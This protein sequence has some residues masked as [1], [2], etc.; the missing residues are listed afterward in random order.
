MLVTFLYSI[1]TVNRWTTIID[2]YGNSGYL[3]YII[4]TVKYYNL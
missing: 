2:E 3:L 1:K 4:H